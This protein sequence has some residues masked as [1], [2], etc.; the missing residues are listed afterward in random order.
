MHSIHKEIEIVKR[1]LFTKRLKNEL[2]TIDVNS[3][4]HAYLKV[5]YDKILTDNDD[6]NLDHVLEQSSDSMFLKKW[7][8]MS[9]FHKLKKIEEFVQE[10]Y[11]SDGKI[12]EK[13]TKY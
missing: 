3:D 7:N 12:K 4:R 5:I 8:R 9:D 6:R 10:K 13:L 2:D 11:K 1:D